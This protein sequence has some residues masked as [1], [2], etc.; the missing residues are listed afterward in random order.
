[1]RNEDKLKQYVQQH[2]LTPGNYEVV[3]ATPDEPDYIQWCI[4]QLVTASKHTDG[5]ILLWAPGGCLLDIETNLSLNVLTAVGDHRYSTA[6]EKDDIN[7][8]TNGDVDP[9]LERLGFQSQGIWH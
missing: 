2:S 9:E 8:P 4:G 3:K 7:W 6:Y 5:K 1:M